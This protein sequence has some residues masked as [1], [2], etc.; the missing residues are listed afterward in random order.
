MISFQHLLLALVVV[1]AV[2]DLP[3][4]ALRLHAAQQVDLPAQQ[5]LGQEGPAQPAQAT[6]AV[7][8]NRT[9]TRAK[10]VAVLPTAGPVSGTSCGT[11]QRQTATGCA[12]CG[13]GQ[14]CAHKPCACLAVHYSLLLGMCFCGL[15]C[16]SKHTELVTAAGCT[17]S[18]MPQAV[19]GHTV[20]S[21]A[22]LPRT[23]CT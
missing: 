15:P 12:N 11:S 23:T 4:C 1:A 18:R 20:S 6:A 2:S 13:W 5:A 19:A 16:A 17:A 7:R 3:A 8:R 9:R 14:V 21:L 10:P 22:V